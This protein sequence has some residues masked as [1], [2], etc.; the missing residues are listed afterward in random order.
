MASQGREGAKDRPPSRQPCRYHCIDIWT[1]AGRW[2]L[3]ITELRQW[4]S[5]VISETQPALHGKI[6]PSALK[7]KAWVNFFRQRWVYPGSGFPLQP[8]PPASTRAILAVPMR[9]AW[10]RWQDLGVQPWRRAG[11]TGLPRDKKKCCGFVL[12]SEGHEQGSSPQCR[13][14]HGGTLWHSHQGL[15]EGRRE[16]SGFAGRVTNRGSRYWV[17]H[18]N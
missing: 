6:K 17:M 13:R 14:H 2:P 12:A 7:K 5:A 11:G 9:Q 16:G 8:C 15:Q 3:A 1:A 18:N 10:L 4:H